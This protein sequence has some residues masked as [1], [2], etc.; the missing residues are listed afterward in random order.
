MFW[1]RRARSGSSHRRRRRGQDPSRLPAGRSPRPSPPPV[2]VT[3]AHLIFTCLIEQPLA[4]SRP[5]KHKH[6]DLQGRYINQPACGR[7]AGAGPCQALI[8]CSCRRALPPLFAPEVSP[9]AQGQRL[10]EQ[11]LIVRS[12]CRTG[13]RGAMGHRRAWLSTKI[14]DWVSAS[15]ERGSASP[16]ATQQSNQ[17]GQYSPIT[18]EKA[19]S[20]TNILLLLLLLP[21]RPP[22]SPSS[23]SSGSHGPSWR[24]CQAPARR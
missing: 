1:K 19:T 7:K 18:Q 24:S 4:G 13:R 8:R 6:R 21:P 15:P 9:S 12:L 11:G 16:E 2:A 3:T 14:S 5:P 10:P 17:S 23:S 22:S 20:H